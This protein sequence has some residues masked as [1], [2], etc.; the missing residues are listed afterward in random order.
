MKNVT[1]GGTAAVAARLAERSDNLKVLNF[2]LI[3][4]PE[5][6]KLVRAAGDI[7]I[8]EAKEWEVSGNYTLVQPAIVVLDGAGEVIPGCT[9]SWKTMGLAPEVLAN[10]M[11]PIDTQA[12]QE[13]AG[14]VPL[15]LFRPLISDLAASVNEKRQIK[16]SAAMQM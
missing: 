8:L 13:P 4:D 2:D 3:S 12:W 7:Y 1:P 11:T 9:W 5:H 10:I 14:K 15:V 16:L 6:E